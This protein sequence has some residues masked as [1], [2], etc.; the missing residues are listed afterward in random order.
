MKTKL[1]H[2]YLKVC[3]KVF[4]KKKFTP[5]KLFEKFKEFVAISNDGKEYVFCIDSK[6]IRSIVWKHFGGKEAFEKKYIMLTRKYKQPSAK[7]ERAVKSG[8][9]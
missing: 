3:C 4:P 5:K 7:L 6:N 1:Y 8:T 2:E 9:I